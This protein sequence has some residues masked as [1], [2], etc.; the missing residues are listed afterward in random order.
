MIPEMVQGAPQVLVSRDA[1]PRVFPTLH[2]GENTEQLCC[3]CS[4]CQAV[5]DEALKSLLCLS[6]CH[7]LNTPCLYE[8]LCEHRDMEMNWE[9]CWCKESKKEACC[10]G[11]HQC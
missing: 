2:K 4:A 7:A 10:G 6:S 9:G 5:L 1:W 3:E 8:P 11:S